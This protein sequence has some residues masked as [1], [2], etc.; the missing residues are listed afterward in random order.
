MAKYTWLSGKEQTDN[1]TQVYC[2]IITKD[3][4]V[5]LVRDKGEE[6]F[7]PVGG[8]IEAGESAREALIRE[9]QE[10]AQLDLVDIQVLGTVRVELEDKVEHQL[11]YFAKPK[12]MHDFIPCKDGFEVE[13]RIFIHYQELPRYVHWLNTPDG[14][15]QFRDLKEYIEGSS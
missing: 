9:T 7:T 15:L 5:A 12:K 2:F 14:K 1:A 6:R 13:E 4:L 8:S 3:G 10:E 11:R